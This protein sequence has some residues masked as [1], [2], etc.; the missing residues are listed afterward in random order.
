MDARTKPRFDFKQFVPCLG[1]P[2]V[3]PRREDKIFDP[4][5]KISVGDLTVWGGGQVQSLFCEEVHLLVSLESDVAGEPCQD[6]L[7]IVY[8]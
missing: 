1:G 8:N 7:F 3:L 6:N 5:S 4:S 2:L